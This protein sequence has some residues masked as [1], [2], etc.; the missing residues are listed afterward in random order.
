MNENKNVS[1]FSR[2]YSKLTGFIGFNND[3]N[4]I[5]ISDIENNIDNKRKNDEII[6]NDTKR[7]RIN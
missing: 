2:I 7:I 5:I 1:F 3:E 4:K 6:F